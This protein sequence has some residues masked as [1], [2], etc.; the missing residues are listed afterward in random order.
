MLKV[1]PPKTV[2]IRCDAIG[3]DGVARMIEW[4]FSSLL[5]TRVRTSPT[6]D[7][8]IRTNVTTY[9]ASEELAIGNNRFTTF[10]LGG[11]QQGTSAL[12]SLLN[13]KNIGG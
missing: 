9:K 1:Q 5:L 8:G 12:L 7:K 13:P 6:A 2:R 4:L 10:D 11:H 3:T